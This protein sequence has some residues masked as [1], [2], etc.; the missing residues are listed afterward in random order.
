MSTFLLFVIINKDYK[1]HELHECLI[2]QFHRLPLNSARSHLI[3]NDHLPILFSMFFSPHFN[4]FM[5]SPANHISFTYPNSNFSICTLILFPLRMDLEG[6]FSCNCK[7]GICHQI[8]R[9]WEQKMKGTLKIF[10]TE[11]R[12]ASIPLK[13]LQILNWNNVREP[14]FS[15]H[16]KINT[17]YIGPKAG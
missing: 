11:M 7:P 17:D 13:G 8:C 14:N 10:K 6:F 12:Q 1:S 15:K 3:Q 5:P 16:L 2:T 4:F 9:N